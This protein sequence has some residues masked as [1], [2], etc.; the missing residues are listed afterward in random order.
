MPSP[1]V[2]HTERDQAVDRLK[3]AYAEGRLDEPTFKERVSQ[4]TPAHTQDEL[5]QLLPL[6]PAAVAEPPAVVGP[7]PVRDRVGNWLVRALRRAVF[8]WLPPPHG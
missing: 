3:T 2:G 1:Q 6:V 4:A 8:C 7:V 5:S